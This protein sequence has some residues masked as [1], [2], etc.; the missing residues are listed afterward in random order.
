MI[1]CVCVWGGGMLGRGDYCYQNVVGGA[2]VGCRGATG[3]RMLVVGGG[4]M[5][6]DCK[7][8]GREGRGERV[9]GGGGD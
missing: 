9:W 8:L 6:T 3:S 2:K 5:G 1:K 4:C 7:L